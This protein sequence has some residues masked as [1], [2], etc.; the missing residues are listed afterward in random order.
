MEL[1]LH[2]IVVLLLAYLVGIFFEK[3]KLTKIIG[4]IL[5]GIL[6][7]PSV[8]N[9]FTETM[10][11]TLDPLIV[12]ALSSIAFLIGFKL[13]VQEIKKI[14][15]Q[16]FGITFFQAFLTFLSVAFFTCL[17][18]QLFG[19]AHSWPT[20]ILLGAMAMATAPATVY[21]VVEEFKSSGP[22]TTLLLA[23]VA[24]DDVIAVLVYSLS[25]TFA[26]YLLHGYS[27]ATYILPLKEIVLPILIG[28]L[29]GGFF[30]LLSKKI[31]DQNICII[32]LIITLIL[33]IYISDHFRI[34]PLISAMLLGFI[35]VNFNGINEKSMKSLT[36]VE[37]I[38]FIFFFMTAGASLRLN[39]LHSAG[40]LAVVY[41]LARWG[42]KVLGGTW[43]AKISGSEKKI[44]RWLGWGLLPQAGVAIAFVHMTARIVP[45]ISQTI[46]AIVLASIVLDEIIG[47][48]GVELA[49]FRSGE[50][51]GAKK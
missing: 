8:I 3:I 40:F 6:V 28:L 41:V 33:L 34:S 15:K 9:W 46:I 27:S 50:A 32:C 51:K 36:K 25:L 38:V 7:G 10:L 31:K 18:M 20:S 47:P 39:S 45:Q 48:L 22:L 30:I 19:L 23:I 16:V 26:V 44:Q 4:Y 29:L 37:D 14:K 12:F 42:G 5:V 24:I 2:L 21:A 11:Y 17:F 35:S 13:Q 43:G 1:I 49:I